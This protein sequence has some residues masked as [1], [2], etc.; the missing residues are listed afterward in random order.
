MKKTKELLTELFADPDDP[1]VARLKAFAEGLVPPPPAPMPAPARQVRRKPK[2]SR[3][4]AMV[5]A[6]PTI[7]SG[8]GQ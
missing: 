4:K 7:V 5:M 1:D 3:T 2:T 6:L 8:R